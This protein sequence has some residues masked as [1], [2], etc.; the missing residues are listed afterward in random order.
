M[1]KT[2]YFFSALS[3]GATKRGN[4]TAERGNENS[5]RGSGNILGPSEGD[6]CLRSIV[7]NLGEFDGPHFEA[8]CRSVR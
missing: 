7:T 4:A 8:S 3:G 6:I 5:Q 1:A 2:T